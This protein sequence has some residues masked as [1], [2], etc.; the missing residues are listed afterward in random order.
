[1]V[2]R[3]RG[4]LRRPADAVCHRAS[5]IVAA[6]RRV[7][8]GSPGHRRSADRPR[9]QS[10]ARTLTLSGS[11]WLDLLARVD[12]LDETAVQSDIVVMTSA[13]PARTPRKARISC[14]AYLRAYRW[15]T[16]SRRG[17]PWPIGRG[18]T[19]RPDGGREQ[20][21]SGR[22]L[23]AGLDTANS[24]RQRKKAPNAFTLRRRS[25]LR[26]LMPVLPKQKLA[27]AIPNSLRQQLAPR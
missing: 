24:S 22:T 16:R 18:G 26:R 12:E 1:M 7:R 25:H 8:S 6:S 17:A 9:H 23:G 14:S 21:R 10:S 13:T 15:P 3:T 20:R 27:P 4:R 2:R 5:R 19:P 11:G